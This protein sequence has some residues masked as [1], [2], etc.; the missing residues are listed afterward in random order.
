[1]AASDLNFSE[2]YLAAARRVTPATLQRVAREYLTAS[3]RTLYALLPAGTAPKAAPSAR[4]CAESA[5]QKMDL[6][7]GL[8]LLVKEDHRLPFVELRAV[9][10][11]GV[12]VETGPENGLTQLMSKMLLQGTR[13]R[14]AEQIATAIESVGGSIESFGGNNSFGL[15]AEVL[16]GDFENRF[17]CLRRCPAPSVLSGGG[18][19]AGAGHPVGIDSGATGPFAAKLQPGHAAGPFWRARLRIG[20]AWHGK[21]RG[22]IAPAAAAEFYQRLAVPDNCVLAVF[23]DVRAGELR[24][25]VQRAFGR[26]KKGAEVV[27]PQ[28]S[29]PRPE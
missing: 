22:G 14:S 29:R 12:L 13:Q 21:Q 20:P 27:P 24:K 5:A 16:S 8:R 2:R 9:F 6:P 19:W 23:G 1:M 4:V 18:F 26:W 3:N 11:G 10:Q 17:R 7:N 28:F 15:T 25:A